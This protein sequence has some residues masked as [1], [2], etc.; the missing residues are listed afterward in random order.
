MANN[1]I[2]RSCANPPP[3][4]RQ[5]TNPP[6]PSLPPSTPPIHPSAGPS[7]FPSRGCCA[8]CPDTTKQRVA[9]GA[10][11]YV[12]LVQVP[13]AEGNQ[14][15]LV[16]SGR[17]AIF[18]M[19][20][21]HCSIKNCVIRH[22]GPAGQ[23]I[24]VTAGETTVEGCTVTSAGGHGIMVDGSRGVNLWVVDS[25]IQGCRCA[26]QRT[27]WPGLSDSFIPHPRDALEGGEVPPSPSR[28]PGLSSATVPMTANAGFNGV[29]NR[30]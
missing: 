14:A 29:C 24:S 1:Q 21:E 3:H 5:P 28:E 27:V 11:L 25:K 15:L 20:G 23:A 30:Q 18:R 19:V 2:P 17:L 16:S 22:E 6:I 8:G 13:D 4:H 12:L 9:W 7:P 26:P 10:L